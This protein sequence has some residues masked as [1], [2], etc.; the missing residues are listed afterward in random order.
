MSE[1]M[2]V[3]LVDDLH[4]ELFD[5]LNH[6][7]ICFFLRGGVSCDKFPK[8]KVMGYFLMAILLSCFCHWMYSKVNFLGCFWCWMFAIVKFS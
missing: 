8:C 2:L 3:V 6:C 5:P 7:V 4:F 1:N